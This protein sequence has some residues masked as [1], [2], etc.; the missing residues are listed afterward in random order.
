[1]NRPVPIRSQ[2]GLTR[3][4]QDFACARRWLLRLCF[5]LGALFPFFCIPSGGA[6][7][8]WIQTAVDGPSQPN[9][10]LIISDDHAWTDYGF[11]GNADVRTPHLDRIA[12]EGLTFTRGYVP[13]ALCSPSLATL[14]TGRYPHQHGITGNDPAESRPREPWLERFFQFPQLPRLLADSGY[15]TLHTGKYWMREPAAA[16]FTDSM[17][18][19]DR[20][21]GQALAIGRDSMQPIF[22]FIDRTQ[23]DNQ[24]FF[25]WYAPFLPHQ[26]HNPPERLLKHYVQIQ[27]ESRAKYYAMVE[28]LDETCGQLLDHLEKRDL[29]RNTLLVFLADNGWNEF[30][31]S[32]PYENGVRT[33]I[34]LRWPAKIQPRFERTQLASSIDIVPTILA[35]CGV[36]APANLPGID[37]LDSAALARRDTVFLEHYAHDMVSAAQPERSLWSRSCIQGDWK[38]IA[39]QANP[40]TVKPSLGGQRHKDPDSPLELYDLSR[41]PTEST[42]LAAQHADVV[43]HLEELLATHWQ[44]D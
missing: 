23:A 27:P 22:E 42:N 3:K 10:I 26:P 34:L 37:L 9:V 28:W 2:F 11:M 18:Q 17:G 12:A 4:R 39:W 24:P 40:P 19:T 7:A 25:V 38:L 33:P 44:S 1:M 29:E 21:G 43:R 5:A 6:A 13:T 35:A 30:G 8:T 32:S 16:G 20:H 14:L 15:R 31:K 36:Q 41:D